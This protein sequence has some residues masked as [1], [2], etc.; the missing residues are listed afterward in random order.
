MNAL[1]EILI[2]ILDT[3]VS[4]YIIAILLRF[5]LQLVR[6]DFYNPLSQAIVKVTNPLLIPLRKVIP[7]LFGVD[8]AAIT[9]AWFFQFILLFV[10]VLISMGQSYPIH[11][12]LIVSFFDLVHTATYIGYGTAIILVIA[13]FIAPYSQH[14][15]LVLSH[16]LLEPILRPIRKIIP[17][18]GGLD[19][20]VLFFFLG[21]SV[22]QIL[23]DAVQTTVLRA[24][25]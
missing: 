8:I 21:L 2:L 14:P 12:L 19:F 13:S 3:L 24:F 7:G 18:L 16:Q 1:N 10:I 9:L 5:L 17:P 11:L 4:L 20:S 15:I 6:A 22:V 25:S 23:I